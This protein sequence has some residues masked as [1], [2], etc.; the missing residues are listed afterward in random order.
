MDIERLNRAIE[1]RD[2]GQLEESLRKFTELEALTD[3]PVERA[4]VLLNESTVLARMGRF[5]DAQDKT[6]EARKTSPSAEVQCNALVSH[7]SGLALAGR[8]KSA[9]AELDHA[10]KVYPLVLQSEHYRFL[11]EDIQVRRGLLLVQLA[12]LREAQV[13]LE[14][15]RS[16]ALSPDDR[17]RVL[18]NLGRCY[19]DLKDSA[20]AKSTFLQFLQHPSGADLAHIAS[21]HFLL[22][23]IYY[24]EG[25]DAKALT[26]FEWLLPKVADVG[27]PGSVL[28]TWL[29]K[30]HKMLGNKAQAEKYRMLAKKSDH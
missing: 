18:Y 19:F 4:M 5:D 22:G 20:R 23:T 14:E 25:S 7:A 2:S 21:A 17:R 12:R 15:C 11:Y 29:A 24:N 3:D 28:Y 8:K 26:E 27:M 30:T 1:L 6:I 16:L 9:L 13:V 10:L